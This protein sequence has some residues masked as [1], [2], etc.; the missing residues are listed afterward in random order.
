M[1]RQNPVRIPIKLTFSLKK[2]ILRT[3][4]MNKITVQN[5][6][7]LQNPYFSLSLKQKKNEAK[8]TMRLLIEEVTTQR[9]PKTYSLLEKI[10]PSI[11][12]HKCFN[13]E[14]LPFS[15]EVL[16]TE[17]GHLFEHVLMEYLH[18]LKKEK[19]FSDTKITG[20]T[21][22]DWS[23][24]KRGIFHIVITSK[25]GESSLLKIAL[26]KTTRLIQTILNS[27]PTAQTI[28][29]EIVSF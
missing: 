3:F 14:E 20:E 27:G 4:A 16:N 6:R 22:W 28:S 1:I 7:I 8:I 25:E 23:K 2:G 10:L 29:P 17:L 24:E 21:I 12:Q 15:Q 5:S 26:E 18:Q 19:G 9:F 13:G 11:Y